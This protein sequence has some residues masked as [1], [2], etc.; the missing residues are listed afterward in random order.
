MDLALRRVPALHYGDEATA[1][2]LPQ[3]RTRLHPAQ[4]VDFRLRRRLAI[5]DESQDVDSAA[6]QAR[7][8]NPAEQPV[9][10]LAV[11]RPESEHVSRSL[12]GNGVGPP[13]IAVGAVKRIDR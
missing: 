10:H 11:T 4:A 5:R 13:L 3:Q 7:L 12:C 8:T 9:E 2:K 6:R 1:D